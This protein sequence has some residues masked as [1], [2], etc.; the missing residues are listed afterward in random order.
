MIRS[1]EEESG[2]SRSKV[3]GGM[4]V[5]MSR[6]L[7]EHITKELHGTPLC[8]CPGKGYS[9]NILSPICFF[10]MERV[11][12]STILGTLPQGR[13]TGFGEGPHLQIQNSS[14]MFNQISL[15]FDLVPHTKEISH[16]N[17]VA[18]LEKWYSICGTADHKFKPDL[19]AFS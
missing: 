15:L 2:L 14:L 7:L 9:F 12:A 8:Q 5:G 13:A 10:N 19:E 16:D 6:Y 11:E 1:L 3:T 4:M 18:V 17:F